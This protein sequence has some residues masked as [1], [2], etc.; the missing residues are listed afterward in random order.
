MTDMHMCNNRYAHVTMTKEP[1]AKTV[2][3]GPL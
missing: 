1:S 3:D 2:C